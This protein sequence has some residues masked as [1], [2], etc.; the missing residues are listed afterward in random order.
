MG[1]KDKGG[2]K[3]KKK[4]LTK[5]EKRA[6]KKTKKDQKR[7]GTQI[8]QAIRTKENL[9]CVINRRLCLNSELPKLQ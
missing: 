7:E 2:K 3:Q 4:G 1:R 5:E 6:K 8:K 9:A